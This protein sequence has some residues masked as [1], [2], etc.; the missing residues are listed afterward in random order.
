MA[1]VGRK[2]NPMKLLDA[3]IGAVGGAFR[4]AADKVKS[5]PSV[6]DRIGSMLKKEDDAHGGDFRI[7]QGR[8]VVT[9]DEE[10]PTNADAAVFHLTMLNKATTKPELAVER[11][12][13][14]CEPVLTMIR[15]MFPRLEVPS[16]PGK[17]QGRKAVVVVEER[18]K[19]I[20]AF[21]NA[22]TGHPSASKLKE[23][24]QLC[25]VGDE[26]AA[27]AAQPQSS[28]RNDSMAASPDSFAA[29]RAAELMVPTPKRPSQ[30][31]ASPS[32]ARSESSLLAEL[33]AAKQRLHHTDPGADDDGFPSP[34]SARSAAAAAPKLAAHVSAP[35]PAAPPPPSAL[36]ASASA[37]VL[38]SDE[39]GDRTKPPKSVDQLTADERAAIDES[40]KIVDI[41]NSCFITK[42]EMDIFVKDLPSEV[43]PRHVNMAID[44]ADK[45]R[46]E[47]FDAKTW[48]YLIVRLAQIARVS[49]F[50]LFEK[51]R[52]ARMKE[53][54][55]AI[56]NPAS[57]ICE[58]FEIDRHEL[59]ALLHVVKSAGLR[60]F[61]PADV[62][63]VEFTIPYSLPEFCDVMGLLTRVVP[64]DETLKALQKGK[65]EGRMLALINAAAGKASASLARQLKEKISTYGGQSC[66]NCAKTEAKYAKL[67]AEMAELRR[68]RDELKAKLTAM[69]KQVQ[70][71]EEKIKDVKDTTATKDKKIAELQEEVLSLKIKLETAVEH[72][73]VLMDQVAEAQADLELERDRKGGAHGFA[74][75]SDDDDEDDEDAAA[76][77]CAMHFLLPAHLGSHEQSP[78]VDCPGSLFYELPEN[79]QPMGF[80]TDIFVADDT[81][82][83]YAAFRDPEGRRS[84]AWTVA[85]GRLSCPWVAMQCALPSGRWVRLKLRLHWERGAF[86]VLLDDKPALLDVPFRDEGVATMGA[87]DIYPR[88]T[89]AVCY[90]NMHFFR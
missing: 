83:E 4:S 76:A 2:F 41:D 1:D 13:A 48:R 25:G 52:E 14:D 21:V 28:P 74:D 47:A 90:A 29:A 57:V 64:L 67:E 24:Q 55:D 45:D 32:P 71:D 88:E 87:V 5:G 89:A 80:V 23:L 50:A 62:A 31:P 69:S 6:A 43:T 34:P 35:A 30:A 44:E 81:T 15:G 73:K 60:Q 65:G 49:V 26:A 61:S 39:P 75:S 54:Y 20:Q 12:W 68:D 72:E 27:R 79:Y 8:L 7:E 37:P 22:C 36:R 85:D 58:E 56:S 86:D 63:K 77:R 42:E 16:P 66:S 40:F 11:R 46:T 9:C 78:A 38:S 82:A 17:A 33:Q 53:I 51:F 84:V 18:R 19:Y 70:K 59:Q 10:T 3:G